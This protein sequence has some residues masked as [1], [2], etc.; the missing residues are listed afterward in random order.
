MD[1]NLL[2]MPSL[3]AQRL[4]DTQGSFFSFVGRI[5]FKISPGTCSSFRIDWVNGQLLIYCRSSPLFQRHDLMVAIKV[6]GEQK[7]VTKIS[8]KTQE[9]SKLFK[10]SLT[11]LYPFLRAIHLQQHFV[12][13]GD[14]KKMILQFETFTRAEEI[15]RTTVD[16]C[17]KEV[18]LEKAP[19]KYFSFLN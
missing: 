10:R 5:Y 4:F 18:A 15:P 7:A 17:E 2:Y 16:G 6:F 11:R 9:D 8:T 13:N 19:R 1:I 3:F 14:A 12:R